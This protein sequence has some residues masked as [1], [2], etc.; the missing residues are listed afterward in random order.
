MLAALSDHLLVHNGKYSYYTDW[1]KAKNKTKHTRDLQWIQPATTPT[2]RS[3]VYLAVWTA[4][5]FHFLPVSMLVLGFSTT[6]NIPAKG[7]KLQ[8]YTDNG[9]GQCSRWSNPIPCETRFLFWILLPKILIF[10]Y[11]LEIK[12]LVLS[13]EDHINTKYNQ[14]QNMT[15]ESQERQVHAFRSCRSYSVIKQSVSETWAWMGL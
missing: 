3:L 1:L 14:K 15:A 11:K 8:L 2:Y 5:G 10:F 13:L 9:H 7:Y 4:Y 6:K 12:A